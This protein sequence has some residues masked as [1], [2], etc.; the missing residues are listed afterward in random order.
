MKLFLLWFV[1][2]FAVPLRFARFHGHWS[3]QAIP[4]TTGA[5]RTVSGLAIALAA[6]LG[7]V[8]AQAQTHA[9]CYNSANAGSV[10]QA[11]WTGC[12][13]MY[14]VAD[15]AELLAGVSAGYKISHSGTYYTFGDSANNVFTGQV[16]S[17]ASLFYGK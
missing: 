8:A 17:L 10:G 3:N 12:E 4:P 7:T 9:E 15:L 16:T 2:F 6:F 14:I 1:R 11:G 5:V 13:E